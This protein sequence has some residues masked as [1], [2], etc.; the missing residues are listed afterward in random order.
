MKDSGQLNSVSNKARIND[1]IFMRNLNEIKLILI[2]S[3]LIYG[4]MVFPAVSYHEK[5]KI[6]D[7][8]MA[9]AP[10]SKLGQA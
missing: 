1:T 2:S 9:T 7:Y 8:R 4:G 3:L 10:L 5:Y 6:I